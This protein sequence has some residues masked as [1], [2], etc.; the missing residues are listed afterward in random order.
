MVLSVTILD[1]DQQIILKGGQDCKSIHSSPLLLGSDADSQT[2]SRAASVSGRSSR[3][4]SYP[5]PAH[6][7]EPQAA[8]ICTQEMSSDLNIP[9]RVLEF[10]GIDNPEQV[11]N[12]KH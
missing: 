6:Q 9:F 3:L 12:C 11:K 10:Q 2:G 8:A 4:R 1:M 7:G 5:P